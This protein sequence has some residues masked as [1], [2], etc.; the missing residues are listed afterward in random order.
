MACLLTIGEI[1]NLAEK[2]RQ[3]RQSLAAL[4]YAA[5]KTPGFD[6]GGHRQVRTVDVVILPDPRG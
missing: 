1:Q 3:G 6:T 4:F 2:Q 5:I